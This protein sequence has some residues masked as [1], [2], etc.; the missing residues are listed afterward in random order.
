MV[1]ERLRAVFDTNVFVSAM[2]SRNPSSPTQE[3]IRRWRNEEFV[4]LVSQALLLELVGKLQERGIGQDQIQEL[5]ATIARLAEWVEVPPV[6]V[7]RVV[8][9]DPDDDQI[10]ACATVGKANYLVTYDPHFDLLE[11]MY[12]SIEITKV[13]PFLWKVRGDQ[14]PET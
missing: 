2:L 7:V 10:L 5:L 12:Q 6:A 3:L 14:P 1:T 11:G 8:T 9:A 13:L 4:L